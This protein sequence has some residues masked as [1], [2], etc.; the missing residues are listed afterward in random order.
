MK[1]LFNMLYSRFVS[2]YIT[3]DENININSGR[4]EMCM[5][6]WVPVSLRPIKIHV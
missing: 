1:L 3:N 5:M 4:R 2:I 6:L